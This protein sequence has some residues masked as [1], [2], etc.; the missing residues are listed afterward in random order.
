MDDVKRIVLRD[1]LAQAQALLE[2]AWQLA[3]DEP[4]FESRASVAKASAWT[5][6]AMYGLIRQFG[7]PL[8]VLPRPPERPTWLSE[9]YRA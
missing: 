4:G 5:A 6:D 3:S 1:K 8:P 9:P 2:E 7:G